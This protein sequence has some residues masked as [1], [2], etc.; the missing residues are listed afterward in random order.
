MRAGSAFLSSEALFN[1]VNLEEG[2]T[3]LDVGPGRTGHIVFPAA[4][5]VGKHGRVIALDIARNTLAMLEGIRRQYLLHHVDFIWMDVEDPTHNIPVQ[6]VHVAFVVNTAWM[7][8]R[9]SETFRKIA[10]V[11]GEGGRI[12]VVDW[13]PESVHAMAPRWDFRLN[14]EKLDGALAHAGLRVIE[15]VHITPW[16]FAHVYKPF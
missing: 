7:F 15:R 6:G 1:L 8:S 10:D 16:H 5:R 2:E 9:H 14:P 13:L 12:V 11:L 4:T 3:V